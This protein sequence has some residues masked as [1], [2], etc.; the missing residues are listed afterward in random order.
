MAADHVHNRLHR[1]GKT[2]ISQLKAGIY[3]LIASFVKKISNKGVLAGSQSPA[4]ILMR[5][6]K[7]RKISVRLGLKPN[8]QNLCNND[9]ANLYKTRCCTFGLLCFALSCRLVKVFKTM[10][11]G[12]DYFSLMFFFKKNSFK[13][14]RG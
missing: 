3:F 12:Q 13:K 5:K 2:L 14:K 6:C 8:A 4:N 9:V 7:G 1:I 10:S 11:H